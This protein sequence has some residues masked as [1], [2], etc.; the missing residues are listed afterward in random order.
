VPQKHADPEIYVLS[1]P[2]GAGESTIATVLFPETLDIDQFVNADLIALEPPP[3]SPAVGVIEP[4]GI[5]LQRIQELRDRGESFAF[6]TTLVSRS[7]V[8]FL[9]DAKQASYIVHVAYIWLATV[10]LALSGV[11]IVAYHARDRCA[12][13]QADAHHVGPGSAARR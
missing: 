12:V 4:G 1:G 3:L 11:A 5:M 7:Y 8:P 10:E 2:N 13:G 6:E 9:S